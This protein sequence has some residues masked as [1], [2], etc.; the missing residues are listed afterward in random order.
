MWRLYLSSKLAPHSKCLKHRPSNAFDN[1][2]YTR[3]GVYE[4]VGTARDRLGRACYD[5]D[6]LAAL[7]IL[8]LGRCA[9]HG[10]ERPKVSKAFC[11]PVDKGSGVI[12][13]LK[14]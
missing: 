12:V 14:Y 3:F 13:R 8:L 5:R 4:I 2:C 1:V 10:L 6:Q 11:Y 9:L 7:N